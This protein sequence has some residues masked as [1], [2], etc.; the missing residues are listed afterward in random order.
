MWILWRSNW[1]TCEQVLHCMYSVWHLKGKFIFG[2]CNNTKRYGDIKS[3]YKCIYDVYMYGVLNLLRVCAV[4]SI[5]V[6]Q[7]GYRDI[8]WFGKGKCD[9]GHDDQSIM[10]L[11][12]CTFVMLVMLHACDSA[13]TS[14]LDIHYGYNTGMIRTDLLL[15][16]CEYF[17][18]GANMTFWHIKRLV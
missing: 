8:A 17:W 18:Y 1:Y 12:F 16:G 6:E 13:M 10:M 3:L 4:I 5:N 11:W 15:F 9:I 7:C 14:F 2:G